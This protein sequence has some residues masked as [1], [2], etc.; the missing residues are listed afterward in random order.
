[1]SACCLH[2]ILQNCAEIDKEEPHRQPHSIPPPAE[3][4]RTIFLL[5]AMHPPFEFERIIFLLCAYMNKMHQL[6]S[7]LTCYVNWISNSQNQQNGP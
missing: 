5:C 6:S 7:N 4:V 2:H 1:M 3:F